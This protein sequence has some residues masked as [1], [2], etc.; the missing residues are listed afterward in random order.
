MENSSFVFW[1]FPELFW[2]IQVDICLFMFIGALFTIA[3]RWKQTVAHQWINGYTKMWSTH[4]I[5]FS[6]AKKGNWYPLQHRGALRTLLS[7][8]SRHE[9]T[10]IGGSTSPR[11]LQS[12]IHRKH[13]FLG[14]KGKWELLFDGY[15]V[16]FRRWKR[17]GDLLHN[18]VNMLAL[19]HCPL[20]NG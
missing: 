15:R 16:C 1:K 5:S 3:K 10:S 19:P 20:K 11:R 6:L 13:K 4:T 18:N 9:R 17:P 14:D 2:S 12:Q 7:E 8:I